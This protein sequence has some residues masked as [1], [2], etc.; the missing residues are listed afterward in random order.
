MLLLPVFVQAQGGAEIPAD[1]EKSEREAFAR[2]V[3]GFSASGGGGFGRTWSPMAEILWSADVDSGDASWTLLPQMQ[4]T[5][6]TRQHVR[7]NVGV[8]LPLSNRDERPTQL[9]FYGLWDW[10]DGGLTDGW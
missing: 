9:V 3:V 2:A 1:A 7:L 10:F 5:L 6:S 4:V 8:A